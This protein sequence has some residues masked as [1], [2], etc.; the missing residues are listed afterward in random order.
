MA[1]KVNQRKGE[2]KLEP[3]LWLVQGKLDTKHLKGVPVFDYVEAHTRIGAINQLRKAYPKS[4]ELQAR[5]LN[6]KGR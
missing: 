1:L 3:F 5:K 2:E 6:G 4:Y